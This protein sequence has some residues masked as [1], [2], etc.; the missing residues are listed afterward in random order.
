LRS[1][2]ER[3]GYRIAYQEFPDGHVV[4]PDLA[5]RAVDWFTR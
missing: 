5:R 3:E 1:R 4:P 2:L